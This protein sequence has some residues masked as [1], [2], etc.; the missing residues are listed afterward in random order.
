MVDIGGLATA[1]TVDSP[2]MAEIHGTVDVRPVGQRMFDL[3]AE[4]FPICRSL[5]GN[6]LRKTLR[7]LAREAGGMM[8][9]EVP[10]GTRCFDWEVPRE[11][12]IRDAYLL[13]PAGRKVID[14]AAS[15][16]HVVS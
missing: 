14:F 13:D 11:W 1:C 5:T 3:I 2:G 9:H 16:L 8:M 4:L 10:T 12:N 15:N 6:G 7:I